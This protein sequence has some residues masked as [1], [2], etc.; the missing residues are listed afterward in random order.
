[1]ASLPK[2]IAKALYNNAT[3]LGDN[4]ALPPEEEEKFL[5]ALLA[6][7]YTDMTENL[8]IVD[9]DNFKSRLSKLLT[10]CMKI[11]KNHRNELEKL[12]LKVVFDTLD[13][14]DDCIDFSAK[15]VDSVDTSDERMKPEATDDFSFED[16]S[17]M[18]KLTKE[19]YKRRV[20]NSLVMGAAMYY[21]FNPETYL[22]ETFRISPELPLLYQKIIQYN[23]I[24]LYM[25]KDSLSGSTGNVDGGKV[26]VYMN[27]P[28]VKVRIKSEGLI[29]PVLLMETFKGVFELSISHGLPEER[30]RAEYIMK[31]ADFKLCENWDARIGLPLWERIADLCYDDFDPS[32]LLMN[33]SKMDVDEFND[34]MQEIFKKTKKG[35]RIINDICDDIEYNKEKDDF[36]DYITDRNNS[37]RMDDVYFTEAELDEQTTT[38]TATSNSS[39]STSSNSGTTGTTKLNQVSLPTKSEFPSGGT[40]AL[41]KAQTS[42]GI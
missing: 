18:K 25:E 28:D 1:M 26:N 10:K 4:P 8:E 14:P 41:V 21:A 29:F 6:K 38:P 12:C 11:E 17:D 30:K 27:G 13:I 24:L 34:S 33:I 5:I 7:K 31:K 35:E 22:S 20:M 42:G 16:I 9:L 19:V 39:A 37:I 40:D 2:H 36:D 15:L 23:A 32:F 3:S